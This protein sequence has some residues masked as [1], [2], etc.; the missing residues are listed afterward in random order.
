MCGMPG[1]VR[2]KRAELGGQVQRP[3]ALGFIMPT[4]PKPKP[5]PKPIPNPNP[6]PN[7]FRDLTPSASLMPSS[8]VIGEDEDATHARLKKLF[9]K[10]YEEKISWLHLFSTLPTTS[11]ANPHGPRPN[12]PSPN[13]GPSPN[14]NPNPSPNPNQARTGASTSST[15]V[16]C[17]L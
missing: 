16:V 17:T 9:V 13:S 10:T 14:P 5:K 15:A 11:T 2:P 6:N 7:R 8:S 3:D 4:N 12:Q 1:L